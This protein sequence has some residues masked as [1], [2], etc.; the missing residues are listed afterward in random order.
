MGLNSLKGAHIGDTNGD[1]WSLDYGS[2]KDLGLGEG[3]C[4]FEFK[5]WGLG[6]RI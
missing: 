4:H 5:V 2:F 6:F 3:F 1:T